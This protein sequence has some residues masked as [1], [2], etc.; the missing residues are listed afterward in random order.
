M[1]NVITGLL[2][3]V[4][5]PVSPVP[6]SGYTLWLDASD[7]ASFTYSSGSLVSQWNDKSGNARNY[8]QATVANQPTKQTAYQN[9]LDVVQFFAGS[10]FMNCN[11]FEWTNG[12]STVFMVYKNINALSAFQGAFGI[13]V[14]AGLT[15]GM[16]APSDRYALFQNGINA[17]TFSLSPT[18]SNA[19]VT[20]W[21]TAGISGGAATVTLRKNGTAA[22][23]A[24]TTTVTLSISTTAQIGAA[25][26]ANGIYDGY[27]CEI[28]YYPSQ[29]SNSDC[30]SVEG[31]LKT[32]WGTP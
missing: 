6:V 8:V 9:G 22:A 32:K 20:T 12:N 4:G 5:G 18:S 19:D 11:S 24:V 7:A 10:D 1:L 13:A 3:Q 30:A 21:R 31:Y 14:T 15:Y 29:L 16:G 2:S 27:I 26:G 23:S 28:L 25:N 17:D